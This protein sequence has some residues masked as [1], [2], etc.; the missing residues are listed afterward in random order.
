MIRCAY[1]MP[2]SV[3]N[4][5]QISRKTPPQW[6]KNR[7]N[8]RFYAITSRRCYV[9]TLFSTWYNASTP[10]PCMYQIWS[11]SVEKHG[12]SGPKTA[13]MDVF[14]RLRR[15]VVT[16]WRLFP[17]GTMR[18][19]HVHVSTKFEAN[20]SKNTATVAQKPPKWTFLRHNVTTLLRH[21]VFF[22]MMRCAYTMHMSVPNMKQIGQKTRPQWPKQVLFILF[23][24]F[25]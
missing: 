12:H 3:P 8:E 7:Q 13:K 4:L 16:S 6:P 2:M 14:T 9:M 18:I 24:L 1:T 5:K 25:K 20:R 22:H 21:D 11:E 15:D 23:Y 10:C 17:H 19:Y